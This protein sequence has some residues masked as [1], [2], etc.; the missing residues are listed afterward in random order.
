MQPKFFAHRGLVS[1]KIPENT[2]ASLKNAVE[3]NFKAVEVDIW[4]LNKQLVVS[5][6]RPKG[7]LLQWED[8]L[9]V[10]GNK[11]EYWCDFKNLN[12]RNAEAA[13]AEFARITKK[14]K[15]KDQ[16]FYF[17]PFITDLKSGLV[18]YQIIRNYYKSAKI[19]AVKE[20]LKPEE[21]EIYYKDLVKNKIYGLSIHY[22]NITPKLIK[23]CKKI[24]IFAWT[25]KNKEACN[26]LC[27]IGIKNLTTDI[28][29]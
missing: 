22:S 10:Y 2:I 11:I 23:L 18:I 20:K 29:L 9:S 28:I 25:I 6:D 17:A 7:E 19:L 14:L 3:N 27:K 16:V 1:K 12:K 15:I 5:H 8:F 24:N 4:Y 13:I 26:Q 21:F